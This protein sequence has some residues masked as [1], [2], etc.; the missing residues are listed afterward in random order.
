MKKIILS[1]MLI[2]IIGAGIFLFTKYKNR[3]DANKKQLFKI[4]YADECSK[5]MKYNIDKGLI[6]EEKAS[7]YCVCTTKIVGDNFS[8]LKE[9]QEKK[10]KF[11]ALVKDCDA[12]IMANGSNKK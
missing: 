3:E 7:E 12:L 9:I 10:E 5:A 11:N 6:S 8:S 4:A 1:G 2:I